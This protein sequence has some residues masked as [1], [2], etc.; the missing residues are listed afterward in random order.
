[1]TKNIPDLLADEAAARQQLKDAEQA[2]S[3]ARSASTA[4]RNRLNAAQ[5]AIDE[6]M[7]DLRKSSPRESDW[8]TAEHRRSFYKPT[9]IK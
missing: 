7:R 1:M 6:A 8:H 2:E 3:I 9:E 4:A 5:K